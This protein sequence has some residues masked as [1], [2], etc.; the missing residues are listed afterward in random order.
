[1]KID[2]SIQ[3]TRIKKRRDTAIGGQIASNDSIDN[4]RETNTSGYRSMHLTQIFRY[5]LGSKKKYR[6][7]D[8]GGTPTVTE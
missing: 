3:I 8:Q 4:I 6:I 5:G 7:G 1:M 2:P